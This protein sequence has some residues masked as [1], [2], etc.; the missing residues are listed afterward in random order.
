MKTE[1]RTDPERLALNAL[2]NDLNSADPAFDELRA[3]V[4]RLLHPQPIPGKARSDMSVREYW[5]RA[6]GKKIL[7][8]NVTHGR[9]VQRLGDWPYLWKPHRLRLGDEVFIYTASPA[10]AL[11]SVSRG[12]RNRRMAYW[13]LDQTL[14]PGGGFSQVRRCR[15][16]SKFFTSYRRKVEA[17]S[18][19]CNSDYHNAE[20][21]RK[22]KFMLA[23]F[24]RKKKK[25]IEARKLW[26]EKTPLDQIMDKTGLTR[27][28]LIRAGCGGSTKQARTLPRPRS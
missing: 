17:C 2:V 27:L 13:L 3:D 21:Q 22:G 24:L 8:M 10:K 19:G 5:L 16:C 15:Q 1:K 4:Q 12:E 28:A 11:L 14:L 25:L 6:V 20:Y 26:K 9:R 7:E 18:P 23:Y